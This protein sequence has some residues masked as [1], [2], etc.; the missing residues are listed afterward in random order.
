MGTANL[1]PINAYTT[2]IDDNGES[3]AYLLCGKEKAMLIDTLNGRE[4]L[5]DIVRGIT[6]LPVVVVNTHGHI[7]HIG[8]NHFFPEAYMHPADTDVYHAHFGMLVESLKEGEISPLPKGD[9]CQLLPLE[10]GQCFDLGGLILEVIP[11]AGHTKGSIALLDRTA[12]LLY[13]GDAINSQIWM[14]LN[15]STS[16]AT[17]LDS[18]NRLDRVRD[19]FDGLYGG[20]VQ[21][22]QATPAAYIDTMKAG[23]QEILA[24]NTEK[25][26][27]W[28]WFEGVAT[29]HMLGENSWILY[30]IDNI[31]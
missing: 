8:G 5:A 9:E 6:N 7:D 10:A 1:I 17:Y 26:D 31:N 25:D 3:S 24:G 19:N 2:L 22:A 30:S 23:V 20:H 29:R 14:Q 12:R 21:Q 4:N 11:V 28:P 27:A 15:H 18:L 13:S 16:L